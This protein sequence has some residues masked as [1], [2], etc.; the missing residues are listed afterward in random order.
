M[1]N[2]PYIDHAFAGIKPFTESLEQ[3]GITYTIL[4]DSPRSLL[5]EIPGILNPEDD[6]VKTGKCVKNGNDM[7]FAEFG[8]RITP[9]YRSHIVFIYD[10]VPERDELLVTVNDIE[11]IIMQRLDNVDLNDV[12]EQGKKLKQ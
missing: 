8:I 10:H 7:F 11:A 1:N 9:G 3:A 12:F 5:G 6:T 2:R 4:D